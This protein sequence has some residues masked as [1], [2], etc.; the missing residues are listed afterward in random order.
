[1]PT[2]AWVWVR[3]MCD[4]PCSEGRRATAAGLW[5]LAVRSWKSRW[6]HLPTCV[7]RALFLGGRPCTLL[8]VQAAGC[9]R[10]ASSPAGF[11]QCF[12]CD[13]LP[14]PW[15][16]ASVRQ[17]SCGREQGLLPQRA[18]AIVRSG[19]FQNLSAVHTSWQLCGRLYWMKLASGYENPQKNN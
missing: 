12:L 19:C 13:L 2:A 4:V 6:P 16:A 1:M 9:S 3:L 7:L 10:P 11:S 15:P 5:T 17:D 18:R 14:R 8:T